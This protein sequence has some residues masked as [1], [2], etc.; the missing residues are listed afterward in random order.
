[1]RLLYKT[2]CDLTGQRIGRLL[3]KDF[4]RGSRR[5][6]W[7]NCICDCGTAYEATAGDL[8]S[9]RVK[10]CGCWN[11]SLEK[12]SSIVTHGQRLGGKQTREYSVWVNMKKRCDN[13]NTQ[14]YARYGGRGITYCPA[15]THFENFL[16]DMGKCP[17]GLEL[18][19]INNNGNYEPENCRWITHKENCNNKGEPNGA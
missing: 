5:G 10:S 14:N 9:G 18:D 6:N 16:A 13:P 7:W 4:A 17:A 12:N 11:K 8:R 19:R 2:A 3:V 1:M 15:W